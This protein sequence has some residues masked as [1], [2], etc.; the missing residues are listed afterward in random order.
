MKN[1]LSI[2]F[3]LFITNIF[4]QI[5]YNG[6]ADGSVPSGVEVTTD[7]Y[8]KS[9]SYVAPRLKIFLNPEI[10]SIETEENSEASLYK[11]KL[12]PL[13]STESKSITDSVFFIGEFQG[14]PHRSSIPPD[15]HIAVGPEHIIHVVNTYFRITDKEGNLLKDIS[16]SQW[17][18]SVYSAASPFDPKVVY[19]HFNNRWIMV[20]LD[21]NTSTSEAF[22]LISVSDD[23]NPLG[24]WYN[25]A[26][27]SNVNGSSPTGGWADYQGVGFD[28]KALYL[29]SN[30]F[31]FSGSY[32]GTRIRIIDNTNLYADTPGEVTWKD[33][34]GITYPTS[35]YSSFGI[36]PVI[37]YDAD[38]VG[39]YYFA[40]HSPYSYAGNIGVYV[41]EDPLGTPTLSGYAVSVGA[42]S[43]PPLAKQLGGGS[44]DI[45]TGGKNIRTE[46]IVKGDKLYF[47][48]AVAYGAKS[49]VHF[50][51]VDLPSKTAEEDLVFAD[52]DHYY[53]YPALAVDE[54][55]HVFF[56]YS[57]SSEEEYIGARFF[58]YSPSGEYSNDILIEPGYGNYVV[59]YGTGRNRWG[60]YMGA[61][62]DP[63]EPNSIWFATEHVA[64]TNHWGVRIAGVR[65]MPY[66]EARAFF[67]ADSISFG[68]IEVGDESDVLS[69][70][71][72]NYGSET[73]EISSVTN[74]VGDI[75][76][77]N[78]NVFPVS[79]NAFDSVVVEMK[80]VPTVDTVYNDY[81]SVVSGSMV[82]KNI[83]LTAEGFIIRETEKFA[84]YG[85]TGNS[86][87]GLL[88]KL[89]LITGEAEELGATGYKPVRSVTIN[90][91][92]NHLFALT[93]S[94][95]D[96][97]PLILILTSEDGSAYQYAYA[98]VAL[99]AFAFDNNG[100]LYGSG[101]D[102]K[103]Y[104]I[105]LEAD[106]AIYVADLP[107]RFAAMTFEH[108]TNELFASSRS[109]ASRD[110]IVKIN[111][112]TG[113]T[114]HVGRTGRNKVMFGLAFDNNGILYAV[115]GTDYQVSNFI[116]INPATGEG[117]L[118]GST[119]VK[120]ISGL[121]FAM[122]G[123]VGINDELDA[124]KNFVLEQNYPNPFNPETTI[125]YS[126]PWKANVTL[127][128]YDLLGREIA[129]LVNSQQAKGNYSVKFNAGN[130][131]SGLYIYKLQANGFAVSKKMLLLK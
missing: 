131:A 79:L 46:P 55:D 110:L 31:S 77:L 119:G 36:R 101:A 26:L 32:Q 90:P 89:N 60:D 34:W 86:S 24:T 52:G 65:A 96:S 66:N 112:E 38:L 28:D 130:L 12:M 5:N 93:G 111:V 13:V 56:T 87:G 4:G 76:I 71:I 48:H 123:I 104:K 120:G 39:D 50:V 70:T 126:I 128:V 45:E 109:N 100:V 19:D 125:K 8:G 57:R 30:L 72:K 85:V 53:F 16:A 99:D 10:E 14:A 62:P 67:S 47:T 95:Y 22:Y 17:F 107:A 7:S 114:T 1:L 127:K 21:M 84:M 83:A 37:M 88:T 129:T 116:K 63:S 74:T 118:I 18:R 43:S 9:A 102:S 117:E 54:A 92:N 103:L 6:P 80:F 33:L 15:P 35:S 75:Q 29:T 113:D 124:A 69:L 59:D 42:Y 64:S 40:V 61:A 27:P 44:L 20:W 98:H 23:E 73:L 121:A 81:L 49:G 97:N 122:D 82:I 94:S 108:N 115:E 11:S 58:V 105:D 2:V 68:Q 91:L 78:G 25:W 3:L 41:L 106:S 51:K